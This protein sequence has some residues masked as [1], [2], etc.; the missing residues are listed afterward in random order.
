MEEAFLQAD[1][2]I[3]AP[4]GGF[5]GL[6][7][8]GIGGSKCGSTAAVALFYK[9]RPGC[10]ARTG[11]RNF[12]GGWGCEAMRKGYSASRHGGSEQA[13]IMNRYELSSL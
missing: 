3:L 6:G 11:I 8:R 13:L 5:M 12:P 4:K 10:G 9:V 2:K 7:E 1:K